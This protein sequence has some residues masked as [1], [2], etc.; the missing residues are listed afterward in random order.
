MDATGTAASGGAEEPGSSKGKG[1]CRSL[2]GKRSQLKALKSPQTSR[3]DPGKGLEGRGEIFKCLIPAVTAAVEV[4]APAPC[5]LAVPSQHRWDPSLL[6]PPTAVVFGHV[7]SPQIIHLGA[8]LVVLVVLKTAGAPT[9]TA[10]RGICQTSL[11]TLLHP[12][13]RATERHLV[14]GLDAGYDLTSCDRG[15]PIYRRNS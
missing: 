7:A 12:P 3:A 15:E 9:P 10:R 1:H 8:G 5:A 6:L 11:R 13:A 4:P 14:H 2:K